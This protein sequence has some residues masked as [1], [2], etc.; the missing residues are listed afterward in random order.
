MLFRSGTNYSAQPTLDFAVRYSTDNVVIQNI[1]SLGHIIKIEIAKGGTNYDPKK[2]KIYFNTTVGYGA[3]ATFTVDSSGS[4]NAV[5]MISYGEG[6]FDTPSVYVANSS[7]NLVSANGSNAALIAYGFGDGES[8]D[9][10]LDDVG[11][12]QNIKLLTRGFNYTSTPGVSL[13][14]QEIGRAHD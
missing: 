3:N 1:R 4:I 12:I 10:G 13:R 8:I 5:S 6:Y 11:R 9:L 14:I 2:D 7:N